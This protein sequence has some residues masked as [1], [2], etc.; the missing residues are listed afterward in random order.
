MDIV[1]P[2]LLRKYGRDHI[3][4]SIGGYLFGSPMLVLLT[5]ALMDIIEP[6]LQFQLEIAVS[7]Q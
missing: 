2:A 4:Q 5:Q 7:R 3:Q 1:L 6:R